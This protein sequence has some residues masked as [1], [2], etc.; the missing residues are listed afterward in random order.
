MTGDKQGIGIWRWGRRKCRVGNLLFGFSS[1]PLVSCEL[2]S[3]IA[4][5]SWKRV[6]PSK[7]LFCKEQREWFTHSCS[8]VKS[9]EGEKRDGSNLLLG[10]KR[11]KAEKNC[12]NM[13]KNTKPF[14]ANHSF[15]ESERAN[16]SCLSLL[17]V[18][19]WFAHSHSLKRTILSERALAKERIPNLEKMSPLQLLPPLILLTQNSSLMLPHPPTS[20]SP[21][22]DVLS[23]IK[24]VG[25][26]TKTKFVENSF[27]YLPYVFFWKDNFR[28]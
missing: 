5:R 6:N 8:S 24:R 13:V 14:L 28:K 17:F 27:L 7:L 4:I 12:Q 26:A 16:H 1:K 10:I 15:F 9:V 22:A 21:A 23:W 18:K 20:P 2:K 25:L 19:E 3:E 11:G